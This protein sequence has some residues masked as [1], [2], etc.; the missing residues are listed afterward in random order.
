MLGL[1]KGKVKVVPYNP[2]WIIKYEQE[3]VLLVQIL[4]G[5]IEDIQHIGSTSIKGIMSK[6]IIDIM[7][8]VKSMQTIEH[9]NTDSLKA[10]KY[11]RLKVPIID[12]VVFAKIT[13]LNN[14]MKTHIVHIVQY[15]GEWWKKH[16]FFRDYLISNEDT[17]R[18]YELFK[19][20]LANKYRDDEGA[21]TR[22]KENFVN[23]ILNRNG[24]NK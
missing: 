23:N 18:E 17:A 24:G 6:P 19:K 2:E 21:Y 20:D 22:E 7:I 10:Y 3:K 15:E 11:Y 12:K 9:F 1:P 16:I 4:G 5:Q 13:D 14:Y 8:G